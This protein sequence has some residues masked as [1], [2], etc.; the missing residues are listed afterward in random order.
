MYCENCF[1]QLHLENQ[2]YLYQIKTGKIHTKLTNFEKKR[3]VGLEKLIHV[4]ND[5]G[6]WVQ[7]GRGGGFFRGDNRLR[8][9]QSCSS[10]EGF[11]RQGRS[12]VNRKDRGRLKKV[13]FFFG[14]MGGL[15]E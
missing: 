8:H 14:H 3:G 15:N 11:W 1:W 13:A 7:K 4:A 12:E 10:F 9:G 5:S 2:K 6:R